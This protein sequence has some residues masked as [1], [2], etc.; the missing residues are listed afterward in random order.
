M[1]VRHT[2]LNR[3]WWI[4]VATLLLALAK[5]AVAEQL[6]GDALVAAL[7]EG[8]YVIVM[9]HPSSPYA[10][11]DKAAAN[12]DNTGLER[13]L[14][15]TG[16]ATAQ[17]M[18]EAIRKL[19][20]PIGEV[21]SSPTYR[22]LEAVRIAQFGPPKTFPELAEGVQ[23]MAQIADAS[24][25]A[26]LRTKVAEAPHARSN[27]LIVTHTPNL[28]GA[29]ATDAAAVTAGEALIFHPDGKGGT[30]LVARIKIEE[31]PKLAAAH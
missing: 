25:S 30:A 6:T 24:R 8:G 18:G 19:N 12:S 13:Q 26:W 5:T 31:W 20:I 21:L 11:P 16:R 23:S 10:E 4:T 9:R 27:T 3:F 29:F 17:A 22:A 2:S 15:A 14:D 1:I 7:R 28:T